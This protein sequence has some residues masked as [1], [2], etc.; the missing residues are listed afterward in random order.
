METGTTTC[1]AC[2]AEAS[3]VIHDEGDGKAYIHVTCDECGLEMWGEAVETTERQ[4]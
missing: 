1:S 2:G 4:W 3:V